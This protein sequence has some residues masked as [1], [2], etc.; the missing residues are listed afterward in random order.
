M[1]MDLSK[2]KVVHSDGKTTTLQHPRGHTVTVAHAMLSPEHKAVFDALSKSKEAPAPEKM[3]KPTNL[4]PMMADGGQVNTQPS[5]TPV[6]ENDKNGVDYNPMNDPDLNPNARVQK[7][8]DGGQVDPTD[9]SQ[10]TIWDSIGQSKMNDT[11]KTPGPTPPSPTPQGYADGGDVAPDDDKHVTININ[12]MPQAPASAINPNAGQPTV[13][14]PSANDIDY[15]KT[16]APGDQPYGT[17]AQASNSPQEMQPMA[18]S[19]STPTQGQGA[20]QAPPD[21]ATDPMLAG[22]DVQQAAYNA[23]LEQQKAGILNEAS[24]LGQEGKAEAAALTSTVEG[25]QQVAQTY[26]NHYSALE[27]ERQNFMKDVEDQHIDPRHYLNSQ[28]TGEKIAT[29]IGLILGGMGG[30]LTHQGNPALDFLNKQIDRDIDAQRLNL[31]K[32]ENLLSANLKQFGNLRDA[33]DMTRVMQMDIVGNQMKQAAAKAMSPIAA[34]RAQEQIGALGQQASQI[35]GQMAMRR[36]LMQGMASQ[37]NVPA[38]TRLRQMQMAGI[39]DPKQYEQ[40]NKEL[41]TGQEV[42]KLRGDVL[43]S[44][45]DL[46]GQPLAGAFSPRDRQSAVQSFAGRIAKLAEGRFNLQEAEQQAQALLPAAGESDDTRQKKLVRLN[47]F[48]DSMNQTPT[49]NG[50]GMS[51]PKAPSAV[52]PAKIQTRN[53]VKYQQVPGGWQKVK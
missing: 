37:S 42:E 20:P 29:G 12:G 48:F 13:A 45:S 1:K 6:P 25:Q 9:S 31:G 39:I 18:A 15:N 23:G 53:G 35:Q 50:L 19:A 24:A 47:Q 14:Q 43:S 8:A 46:N 4:Q 28:G 52:P 7:K 22:V 34:A 32:S 2:F 38:A 33:T 40:A 44:F 10:K 27:Q 21:A 5:P 36:A 49:L 51:I 16:P 30:G 17:P 11:K 26:Q 3:P 41:G